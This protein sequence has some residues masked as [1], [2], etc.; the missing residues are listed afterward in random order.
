MIKGFECLMLVEKESNHYREF[1]SEEGRRHGFLKNPDV[2][3]NTN[4][5]TRSVTFNYS[6]Y[7]KVTQL[8]GTGKDKDDFKGSYSNIFKIEDMGEKKNTLMRN[9]RGGENVEYN[10]DPS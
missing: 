10:P 1:F 2:V 9:R 6:Q 4:Q 7:H 3:P 5:V 8:S